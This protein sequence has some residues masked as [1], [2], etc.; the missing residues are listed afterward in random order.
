MKQN[1]KLGRRGFLHRSAGLAV[2]AS[3]VGAGVTGQASS[4]ATPP[5]ASKP[6]DFIIDAHIH[7]GGSEAWVNDLLRIYRPRKVMACVL[8]R[9][10]DMELMRKAT[11]EHPQVFL[12]YGYVDLDDANAVREV[13][14]FHKNG[15]IGMKFHSPQK[16]YDDPGYFQVYRLCEHLGLHMLFHTGV[17]SRRISDTPRLQ[18]AS[19]MRPMFLDTI[20]RVCP[21]A[22]LQG[23][24]L[25]NPW[26]E[27]AAEAA[28]WNPNLFFD[29]TGST[30][31]KF[32]KLGRLERMSEILWWADDEADE[33]PH[34]LKGGPGAW[35]HIVFGTDEA[36]SGLEPNI[37][38][39]Q[40]MLDANK[41]PDADRAKMWGLTMA[42]VL[43]IDP[44][45]RQLI[46]R[47]S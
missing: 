27:E 36:P 5:V 37:E 40:K 21:R 14:T 35:E 18:S 42:R 24:H 34:T 1:S 47:A 41:V 30:L 16:D 46:P 19:R 11:K 20:S 12:G 44:R 43:G 45:T 4:Q 8:T 10:P 25:G 13:E 17:T 31:L 9:M 32:I 15:F 26:Y 7:C 29:V 28:R 38:R 2:A 39:F 23:A 22:T 33:N 6:P 3:S